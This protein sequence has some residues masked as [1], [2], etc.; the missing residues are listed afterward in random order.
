MKLDFKRAIEVTW[1]EQNRDKLLKLVAII[2]IAFGPVMIGMYMN[3]QSFGNPY[4]Y[5]QYGASMTTPTLSPFFTVIMIYTFIIM[6]PFI[7]YIYG[8]QINTFRNFLNNNFDL[9]EIDMSHFKAG[10]KVLGLGFLLGLIIMGIITI[11]IMFGGALGIFRGIFTYIGHDSMAVIPSIIELIAFIISIFLFYVFI[12]LY[13]VSSYYML[14]KTDKVTESLSFTKFYHFVKRYW[15]RLLLA[16]LVYIGISILAS[17][18]MQ[19]L[20]IIP[21]I[22]WILNLAFIGYYA[23]SMLYIFADM[24][25]G[26]EIPGRKGYSKA[27]TPSNTKDIETSTEY[28]SEQKTEK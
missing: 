10:V 14:A 15:K 22:G 24:F 28:K 4:M 21:Y 25:R 16:G 5:D 26:L 7:L 19:A 3:G 17:I 27:Q 1:K 23:F 20:V 9:P 18:V 8:Y 11:I 2:F 6:I 12:G 13:S